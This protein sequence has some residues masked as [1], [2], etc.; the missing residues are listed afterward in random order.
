[1]QHNFVIVY[2]QL[3]TIYLHE[4]SDSSGRY[5]DATSQISL[6]KFSTS[7]PAETVYSYNMTSCGRTCRSLSQ[8]DYSCQAS[9]P[10]VDG[11]GCAE[12]TYMNEEGKC[13]S[14]ASCPCYDRDTIIPSGQT[15]SKDG[16]TW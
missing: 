11:C 4:K 12:E 16:T 7:C 9:F 15:V 5:T 1:M 13:V 10:T 6:G 2:P 3:Q 8:A 14:S